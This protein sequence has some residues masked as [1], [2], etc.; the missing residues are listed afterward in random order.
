MVPAKVAPY[1]GYL[2]DLGEE[3]DVK[4][5]GH[6][7]WVVVKWVIDK[8]VAWELDSEYLRRFGTRC[9]SWKAEMI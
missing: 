4:G 3:G 9:W 2:D 1:N 8:C 5:D 7:E 6:S